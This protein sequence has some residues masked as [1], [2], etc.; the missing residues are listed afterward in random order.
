MHF[1]AVEF[2]EPAP[3]LLILCGRSNVEGG[4]NIVCSIL[5]DKASR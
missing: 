2:A 3:K 4:R 5:E 1:I